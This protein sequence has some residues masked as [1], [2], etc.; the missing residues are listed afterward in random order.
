M[1]GVEAAR[2]DKS[3]CHRDA[4]ANESGKVLSIRFDGVSSLSSG[5]CI[6]GRWVQEVIHMI[7]RIGQ[8][9]YSVCCCCC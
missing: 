2:S 4:I 1:R 3:Q 9:F 8:Q 7:G 6:G 5:R